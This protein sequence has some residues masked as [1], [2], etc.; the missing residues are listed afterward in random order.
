MVKLRLLNDT[1]KREA[2]DLY[3]IYKFLYICNKCGAVYGSDKH[4]KLIICPNCET[5]LLKKR[6]K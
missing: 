1:Q 4:E 3:K 2:N 5:K 6:K